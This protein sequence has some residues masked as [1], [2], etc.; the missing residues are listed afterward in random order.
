MVVLPINGQS[1]PFLKL[2]DF[3]C[4]CFLRRSSAAERNRPIYDTYSPPEV[5]NGSASA[6]TFSG[7]VYRL[8]STLFT[9]LLK[10]PPSEG[11][12]SVDRMRGVFCQ[13]YRWNSLSA[14]CKELIT[15]LLS[16]D[17]AA[18]PTCAEVLAHP[19]VVGDNKTRYS[20]PSLSDSFSAVI[21]R[22]S[23]RTSSTK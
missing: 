10:C 11:I 7:D 5:V 13:L 8:G 1:A 15:K 17:P 19:W 16:L 18:R 3:G 9:M 4:A 23:S 20:A 12:T 14:P 22:R 2:I 21:R 6:A